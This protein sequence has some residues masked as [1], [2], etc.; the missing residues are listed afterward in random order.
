MD[1]LRVIEVLVGG[2]LLSLASLI[3]RDRALLP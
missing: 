1:Y 2:L 3:T